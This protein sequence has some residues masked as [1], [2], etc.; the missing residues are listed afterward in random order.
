VIDDDIRAMVLAAGIGSRL[1][2]LSD[3][4][5]KP[6]IKIGGNSIMGH[7][8]HLLKKHGIKKIISNTHHLGDKIQAEFANVNKTEG[9]ELNFVHEDKLSGVAGGIRRC[10]DFLRQSTACII[11]GD[12]LTDIDLSDLY[13]KHKQA[14]KKYNCIATV[15]QMQVADSSHFGVIVTESLLPD[16]K[17]S[18][19]EIDGAR[20]VQFQEKPKP[21]E[22]LSNWANTGVYFFEPAI[23]DYIPSIEEAPV[24][25][26]AK[27]LFPRL[28]KEG[29]YIQAISVKPGTYWADLGTPKQYI[30][31]IKDLA[32][33]LIK[34]DN[35]TEIDP[36]SKIS[37][38]AKLN[39]AIE[40][41]K[42]CLIED[43]VILEDS[44]LW[45]N[46]VVKKG[47][48]IKNS[49]IGSNTL[50]PESSKINDEIVVRDKI[51]EISS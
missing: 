25:D 34:L 13:Q 45:D 5:P 18:N 38:S 20:I 21:D 44:I 29:K 9:I 50:I 31:S 24:Y 32:Q 17:K 1:Q 30:Q 10:Q 28:L 42:N 26:V 46:V 48:I 6:L 12:A 47:S 8:L 19:D 39:G 27:N 40:M 43:D 33:G 15:A 35:L 36:S 11:M 37:L 22:A 49:I 23:Y 51:P 3:E 41:G 2:P 16:F 14:V 7:I 4:I